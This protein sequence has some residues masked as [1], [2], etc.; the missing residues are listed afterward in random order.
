M[1]TEISGPMDTTRK[2]A[3][4]KTEGCMGYQSCV[5]FATV[6]EAAKAWNTRA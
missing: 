4:C 6:R 3:G 1:E 5:T 2:S